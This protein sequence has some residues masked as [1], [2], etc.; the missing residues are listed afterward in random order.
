[1]FGTCYRT[2]LTS[3]SA[4]ALDQVG[5]LRFEIDNTY[6]MKIYRYVQA[7]ADTTVANGTALAF[8]TDGYGRVVT[9]DISDSDKNLPAGVGIGAITASYYGW[10]QVGGYHA[11]IK[12][13]GGDDFAIGDSI[14]LHASSDGVADR[15]ATGTA[16]VSKP[17]GTAV[18]AD[19]DANDTVAGFLYGLI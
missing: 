18:A 17:L 14:I 16:A 11:A 5:M 4:T 19:V 1:M 3:N 6:G 2:A 15:T 8:T 9:S 10:I 7:A 12:T 13:D